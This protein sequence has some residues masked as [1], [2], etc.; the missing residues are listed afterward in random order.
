M[1]SGLCAQSTMSG[2]RYFIRVN[3]VYVIPQT[4]GLGRG[5]PEVL[6]WCPNLRWIARQNEFLQ[7]PD[8]LCFFY[9]LCPAVYSEL[10]VNVF[11]V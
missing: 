1:K 3:M 10:A 5:F 8:L 2:C 4:R 7:K 6:V 11:N 9:S